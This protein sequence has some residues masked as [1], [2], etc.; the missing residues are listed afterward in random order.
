MP[1]VLNQ[2]GQWVLDDGFGCSRTGDSF[3]KLVR[4][5]NDFLLCANHSVPIPSG[6][7]DVVFTNN[8]PVD[9]V[10]SLGAGVSSKEIERLL[11]PGGE[12]V[13]NNAVVWKKG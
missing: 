13:D 2:Q 10:T 11:K 5:G 8:V 4:E 9:R 7:L 6:T 1:G 12:W 3:R